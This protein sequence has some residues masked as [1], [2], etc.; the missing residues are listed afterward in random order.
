[1]G[2]ALGLTM[3]G[4]FVGFHEADLF[5]KYK[6]PEVYFCYIDDTFCKKVKASGDA[7]LCLT[8]PKYC[9]TFDS[10]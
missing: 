6:A 3:A 7:E 1:M 2:S 8:L 10:H 9:K 5:S 4:I